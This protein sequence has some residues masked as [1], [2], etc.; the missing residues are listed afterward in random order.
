MLLFNFFPL[1][2]LVGTFTA[3]LRVGNKVARER[4]YMYVVE[5]RQR[6]LLRRGHGTLNSDDYKAKFVRPKGVSVDLTYLPYF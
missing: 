3:D 6:V 5:D 4:T 2:T 1:T